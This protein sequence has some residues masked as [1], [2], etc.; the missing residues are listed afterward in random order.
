MINAHE[1]DDVNI[2]ATSSAPDKGEA[3]NQEKLEEEASPRT[4]KAL[5]EYAKHFDKSKNE[6]ELEFIEQ[7]K[8]HRA[9]EERKS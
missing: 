4:K 8:E 7:R 9:A 5:E 1:D 3:D 2:A 6:L